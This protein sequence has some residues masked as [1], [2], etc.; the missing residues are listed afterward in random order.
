MANDQKPEENLFSSGLTTPETASSLGMGP[1]FTEEQRRKNVASA[2]NRMMNAQPSGATTGDPVSPLGGSSGRIGS[3]DSAFGFR[4]TD[5]E[6]P[7]KR[8]EI[9]S[10]ASA[11]FREN[12]TLDNVVLGNAEPSRTDIAREK[13]RQDVLRTVGTREPLRGGISEGPIARGNA[14]PVDLAQFDSELTDEELM[15]SGLVKGADRRTLFAA[16][17]S[18]DSRVQREAQRIRNKIEKRRRSAVRKV[19]RDEQRAFEKTLREER[20]AAELKKQ[21]AEIKTKGE[22]QRKTLET[23]ADL[24]STAALEA[25]ELPLNPETGEMNP[26]FK[27]KFD[28]DVAKMREQGNIQG[29]LELMRSLTNALIKQRTLTTTRFDIDSKTGERAGQATS[30]RLQNPETIASDVRSA[31][32]AEAPATSSQ[33]QSQPR[34]PSVQT[35]ANRYRRAI[36]TGLDP[37]G[38]PMSQLQIENARKELA[39]I[40]NAQ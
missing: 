20:D 38:N 9:M 2:M 7:V 18:K 5:L 37:R 31:I 34:P 25:G 40:T 23:Q 6:D 11:A 28:N 24:Q 17:G 35:L 26:A 13:V 33:E 19:E 29:E 15:K 32:G 39:K 14:E 36:E 4:S 1:S 3:G 12:Q 22:E 10:R 27:Q 16:Q 30:T 8:A 21:G